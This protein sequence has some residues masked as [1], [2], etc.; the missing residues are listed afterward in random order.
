M[1]FTVLTYV[2][3]GAHV[4]LP[5]H[6]ALRLWRHRF[7]T[8]GAWA[9]EAGFTLVTLTT[10]FFLGR[11]DI[12]GYALRYWLLLPCLVGV[13]ASWGSVHD[14]PWTTANGIR[15]RWGALLEGGLLAGLLIW[16]GMGTQP[17]R[18][19][20]DLAPPLRGSDYYV[21]HGGGT[22]PLNYHGAASTAQRYAL[23]LTQL[24]GWGF[25]A[26]GLRPT[27]LDAYAVYGDT[28]YSP[29]TGTVVEAVDRFPDRLAPEDQPAAGNHLWLRHD[30]L[31]VVLAHLRQG[32][33]QVEPGQRVTTGQPVARVGHTG[34][35]TEPHLHLHAVRP[36]GPVPAPDSLAGAPP[37]PITLN[38]RFLLR[39]D[40]LSTAS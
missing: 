3:A 22:P 25:R 32:S 17:D 9:A 6:L 31:Y 10:F 4:V 21:A 23:D 33:V 19:A 35:T 36:N 8:Q 40:R 18:P 29:V 15:W 38:G 26:D 11:W 12:V 30:A 16:G 37:V 24:N 28:V 2:L 34:N 7:R 5:P 14:K 20:A 39:N 27:Q 13:V 1:V